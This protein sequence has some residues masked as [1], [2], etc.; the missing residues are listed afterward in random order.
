MPK[1]IFKYVFVFTRHWESSST[2]THLPKG[3]NPKNRRNEVFLQ[4]CWLPW[5]SSNLNLTEIKFNV[6][7]SLIT[8][9]V[10][11]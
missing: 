7:P 9:S 2:G 1:H 5:Q 8:I 11:E 3:E 10:Q 4:G 6:L